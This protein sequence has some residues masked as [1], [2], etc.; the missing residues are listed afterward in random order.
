MIFIMC[1]FRWTGESNIYIND[2]VGETRFILFSIS[3]LMLAGSRVG[4]QFVVNTM[5]DLTLML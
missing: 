4:K 5:I 1:C 2:L 3:M